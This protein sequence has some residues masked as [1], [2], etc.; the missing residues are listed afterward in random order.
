MKKA[1]IS[2]CVI[3][4]ASFALTSCKK[5]YTCECTFELLGTKHSSTHVIENSSKK[6]AKSKCEDYA[7]AGGV[8][9]ECA[10]K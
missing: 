7:T 10:L 8:T 6:D 5:D 3:A 4:F 9:Y 1:I 2:L